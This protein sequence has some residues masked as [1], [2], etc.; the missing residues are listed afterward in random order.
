MYER[1]LL[2]KRFWLSQSD[3]YQPLY[4]MMLGLMRKSCKSDLNSLLEKEDCSAFTL[5][6]Y[7]TSRSVLIRDSMAIMHSMNAKRFKSFGDLAKDYFKVLLACFHSFGCVVDVFDRYD[8]EQSVK[9]TERKRRYVGNIGRVFQIID[10]RPIPDWKKI[11]SVPENKTGLIRFLG[12]YTLKH[13]TGFKLGENDQIQL[14]GCFQN[15]EIAMTISSGSID[16][17]PELFSTQLSCMHCL[18]TRKYH[19]KSPK[20]TL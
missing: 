19:T 2:Q 13:Y 1:N 3:S 18:Q 5:P 14:A 15:P 8:V 11:I 12:D 9:S 16:D 4:S 6:Q 7:D 20:G 10:S 17:V